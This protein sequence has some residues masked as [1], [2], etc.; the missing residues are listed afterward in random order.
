VEVQVS[1]CYFPDKFMWQVR[2]TLEAMQISFKKQP[3][4][5]KHSSKGSWP[6]LRNSS[7][8][9]NWRSKGHTKVGR[10][11]VWGCVSRTKGH[12]KWSDLRWQEGD[13][14]ADNT[15]S[16]FSMQMAACWIFSKENTHGCISKAT[17]NVYC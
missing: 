7:P 15:S 12:P 13:D 3:W 17:C 11:I 4:I 8:Q 6:T 1:M 9:R 5:E 14:V 16:G 2:T 10:T